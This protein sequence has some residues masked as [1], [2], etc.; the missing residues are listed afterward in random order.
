MKIKRNTPDLLIAGETPW[1]IAFMLSFFIL[2]FAGIGI[3]LIS[4]GVWA[5]LVFLVFGGGLGVGGMAAFVERLQLIMDASAGTLTMR[6]RTIFSYN[7]TVI[8]LDDVIRAGTESG[9]SGSASDFDKPRQT[10]SR[11]AFE[12]RDGSGTG[13]TTIVP[14]T[15]VMSNGQGAARVTRAANEW[16]KALRGVEELTG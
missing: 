13:S 14:M 7:E 9:K 1:F 15:E 5:G 6:R 11:L 3:G 8:P 2:V 12:V 16:L 10:V 4:T